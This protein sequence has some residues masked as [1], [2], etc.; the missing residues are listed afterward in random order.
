MEWHYYKIYVGANHDALDFV[1]THCL[2]EA[3]SKFGK[4]GWFFLRYLDDHGLHLRIRIRLPG[5]ESSSVER[6]LYQMIHDGLSLLSQRAPSQYIP[7]VSFDSYAATPINE[8]IPIYCV[9]DR[10]IPEFDVFGG[11]SGMLIAESVFQSSSAI[12]R[13]LLLSE[14]RGDLNRKDFALPLFYEALKVW[15]DASAIDDFLER[16]SNFW[17]S[18]NPDIGIYKSAFTEKAYLMLEDGAEIIAPAFLQETIASSLISQWR[19]T[20][21]QAKE[22]YKKDCPVYTSI[23]ADTLAFYFIHLM[24]NRLGFTTLDE[25]Y[26]AVLLSKA[27]AR[28]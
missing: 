25:S 7:L 24:N 13:E 11:E 4:N 2:E 5:S 12:A 15:I 8:N 18:G 23:L 10:Y 28:D 14:S 19:D 22:Q 26:L 1:V 20:L 9:R 17:L 21:R 27:R 3:I 16:Y 6:E